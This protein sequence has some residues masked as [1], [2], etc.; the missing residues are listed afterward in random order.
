ML[1]ISIVTILIALGTALREAI[2]TVLGVLPSQQLRV[3]LRII[4][5]VALRGLLII[6]LK[7]VIIVALNM[8]LNVALNVAING[9]LRLAG[10]VVALMVA[11]IVFR[12][13]EALG[14]TL[15][16]PRL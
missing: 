8:P 14:A 15:D 5:E 4:I 6:A 7:E 1:T 11:L 9:A 3:A 13:V 2:V 12:A 16:M 10:I